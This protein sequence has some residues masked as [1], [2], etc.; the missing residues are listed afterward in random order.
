MAVG[1]SLWL[2]HLQSFETTLLHVISRCQV[3][4][5]LLQLVRVIWPVFV[6]GVMK[7]GDNMHG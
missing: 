1:F 2:H 5:L 7:V 4:L 3:Q 6:C